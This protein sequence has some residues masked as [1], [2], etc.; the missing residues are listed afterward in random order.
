MEEIKRKYGDG[1]M[2][3]FWTP[4]GIK[5]RRWDFRNEERLEVS[6][7]RTL[8]AKRRSFVGVVCVL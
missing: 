7:W 6:W 5:C 1:G 3:L 8:F 2:Y 4:P